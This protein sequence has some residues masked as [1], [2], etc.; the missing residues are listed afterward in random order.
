MMS[1]AMLLSSSEGRSYDIH[2]SSLPLL[3]SRKVKPTVSPPIIPLLYCRINGFQRAFSVEKPWPGGENRMAGRAAHHKESEAI[4][5][6]LLP[7]AATGVSLLAVGGRGGAT[8]R[9]QPWASAVTLP[10]GCNWRNARLIA[11]WWTCHAPSLGHHV[12]RELLR[13]AWLDLTPIMSATACHQRKYVE[14]YSKYREL[15]IKS[16]LDRFDRLDKVWKA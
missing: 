6:L 12:Y 1:D 14:R 11:V 9:G 15:Y 4:A 5:P 2:C 10:H 8:P 16:F 13:S 7:Y 3:K